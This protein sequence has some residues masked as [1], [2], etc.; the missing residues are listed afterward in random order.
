VYVSQIRE[1]KKCQ[2]L[3]KNEI[4]LFYPTIGVVLKTTFLLDEISVQ[5]AN[6]EY[7]A[8]VRRRPALY[9]SW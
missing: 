7:K 6:L 3:S 8:A 1:G 2:T 4:K 9:L 5:V